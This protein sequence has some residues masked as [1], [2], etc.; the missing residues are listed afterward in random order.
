MVLMLFTFIATATY[1][2]CPSWK[3]AAIHRY[4]TWLV[5]LAKLRTSWI[6]HLS[7]SAWWRKYGHWSYD[8]ETLTRANGLQHVLA[9]FDFIMSL[10][11]TAN[12]LASLRP[13]SIKLQ[14][15]SWDIV[16]A[17]ELVRVTVEDLECVRGNE[18]IMDEWFQQASTLA[19]SVDTEPRVPRT[20]GRQ[21]HRSNI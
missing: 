20:T 18:E 1:S 21:H 17:Y 11:T 8:T 14:R 15:R 5:I 9:S 4:G 19:Q 6:I 2:T 10:T 13:L 12:A 16:R 7:A 3:P